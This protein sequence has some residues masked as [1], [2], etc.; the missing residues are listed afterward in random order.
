MVVTTSVVP[1]PR[2]A[3]ASF[4]A[5]PIVRILRALGRSGSGAGASTGEF[6]PHQAEQ[7]AIREMIALRAQ[8]K[9]LRAIAQVVGGKGHRIS[10]EGVAGVLKAAGA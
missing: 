1:S 2:L 6:V 9:P 8:G 10:H 3:S 5:V 7:D 4:A